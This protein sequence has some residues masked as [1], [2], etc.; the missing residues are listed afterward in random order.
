MNPLFR[1][2]I[3][4]C[5]TFYAL[6]PLSYA[7]PDDDAAEFTAP[8][9]QSGSLRLFFL[10]YFF[11]ADQKEDSAASP[12]ERCLLRKKKVLTSS[13]L[14]RKTLSSAVQ[15]SI[16]APAPV[17]TISRAALSRRNSRGINPWE[18]FSSCYSNHSPPSA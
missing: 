9:C 7:Q 3:L 11:S 10:E 2:A 6:S 17:E 16:A 1:T 18:I 5:F 14:N 4:L 15:I 8:A 12:T 13:G